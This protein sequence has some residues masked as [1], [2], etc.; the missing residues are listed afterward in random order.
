[1]ARLTKKA[2]R[3]AALKGWRRRTRNA[4]KRRNAGSSQ[5]SS[6]NSPTATRT[7]TST[8]A[9]TTG[10]KTGTSTGGAV[11]GG[12]GNITVNVKRNPPKGFIRCSG[13]KI[14][15]KNGRTEVRIRK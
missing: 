2:R 10:N 5:S 15:R 14:T 12:G 7:A 13:V 6:G 11:S 3:N 9:T 1:M 8:K 4:P